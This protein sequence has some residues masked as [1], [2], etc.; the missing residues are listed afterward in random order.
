[1]VLGFKLII[2]ESNRNKVVSE[3]RLDD[4]SDEDSDHWNLSRNQRFL[5]MEDK[6]DGASRLPRVEGG[7]Y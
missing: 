7:A 4:Q 5:L 6:D 1:V 2:D 3:R